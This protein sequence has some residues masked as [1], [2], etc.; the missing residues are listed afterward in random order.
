VGRELRAYNSA[1]ASRDHDAMV[2]ARA[3][4]IRATAK[5]LGISERAIRDGIA[6][7]SLTAYSVGGSSW[8]TIR[9]AEVVKWA[10]STPVDPA[11]LPAPAKAKARAL[12]A[13]FKASRQN[14]AQ[15][16][17]EAT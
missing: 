15:A 7:G 4:V 9:P 2:E 14:L 1:A 13:A 11:S 5:A 16:E 8:Y 10:T 3:R 6:D 17:G 12:H